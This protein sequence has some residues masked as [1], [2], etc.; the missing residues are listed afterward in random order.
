MSSEHS[1]R[2]LQPVQAEPGVLVHPTADRRLATEQW[3][4][5][6]LPDAW[7]GPARRDWRK[8]GLTL[9]PLGGLFS[10]VR[11]P[12]SLI[13]AITGNLVPHEIDEFLTERLRGG[14]VICNP[15]HDYYYALVPASVPRTW[16]D[17]AD[18]WQDVN[19]AVLGRDAYL[20][21]PPLDAVALDPAAPAYW[22]VP[23]ESAE[24]L[25]QPLVVA[26]L[27]ASG[28]GRLEEGVGV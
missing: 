6:T 19:V 25:C 15:H 16:R 1:P 22:S 9:L 17:A 2:A 3:L 7:R 24:M 23:M 28:Q 12:S 20:G 26:R 10:A 21:V 5:S 8:K 13:M 18:D 14:P 4:L 27:I 11:I